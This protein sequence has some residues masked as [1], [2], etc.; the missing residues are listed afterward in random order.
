[1]GSKHYKKR[2]PAKYIY[3]RILVALV[4]IAI[5]VGIGALGVSL[6]GGGGLEDKSGSSQNSSSDNGNSVPSGDNDNKPYVVGS[7]YIG[8]SG[9]VMAHDKQLLAAKQSDGSY[10]FK[11]SFEYIK[12][13][14]NKYDLMVANVEVAF[15][16]TDA[17]A[18]R[19]YPGFNC[20]D[21]LIDAV[22]YAGI[23]VALYANN[24][25]YDQGH[26]AFLRSMR[27]MSDKGLVFTGVRQSTADKRWI[28]KDVNGIKV[29]IINYTYGS[30]SPIKSED[31]PLINTFSAS[32][33]G[34]FY[35]E[36]KIAFEE[37][38]SA[39][40]D[41][42]MIYIH[43]GEE[44]KFKPNSTQTAISKKLCE[45][46]YDVLVGGHPHV[47]QPFDNIKANNGNEML[48]MYSV[49]NLVSNQRSY[50]LD[51]LGHTEDA[52]IFGVK[53]DKYSDGSVKVADVN[54]MPLW[55][56]L[57]EATGK[58]VYRITALDTAVADWSENGVVNLSNAKKSYNRTMNIVGE[59]LNSYRK[60]KGWSEQKLSIN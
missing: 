11:P 26:N 43:W 8:S 39:G 2:T 7:A 17:G 29:G 60:A 14:F 19:G 51:N 4:C 9:D 57:N 56:D 48:C 16:G 23:D 13:Y 42:T 46:G 41:V 53:F 10:N 22:K 21:S 32:N 40:A 18:Y 33:L 37:M 45:T 25:I 47:I 31:A 12:A 49:G 15:G 1:M 44:Y 54:I 34:A 55:V 20:P 59:G 50:E 35:S 58:K 6:F 3:R 36:T 38:K 24:H 27:V 28:I 30:N 52:V 5:V